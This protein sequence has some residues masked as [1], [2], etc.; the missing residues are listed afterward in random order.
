MEVYNSPASRDAG[1]D[2]PRQSS[3]LWEAPSTVD[4][5]ACRWV[6]SRGGWWQRC[7]H[8]RYAG[9]RDRGKGGAWGW[10]AEVLRGKKLNIPNYVAILGYKFSWE[11][12]ESRESVQTEL[13][14]AMPLLS[15]FLLTPSNFSAALVFHSQMSEQFIAITSSCS[16]PV[17][18]ISKVSSC[19]EVWDYM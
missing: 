9:G 2:P 17:L 12:C 14:V 10:C 8:S 5:P 3:A 6:A 18:S 19:N 1:L 4:P 7:W 13:E 16:S 15:C 11:A